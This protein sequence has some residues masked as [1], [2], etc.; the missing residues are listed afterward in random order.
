MKIGIVGFGHLGKSLVKGLIRSN[1]V[2]PSDIYILAKSD[3]TKQKAKEQYG[4]YPADHIN[5]LVEHA[6]I[7]FWVVKGSAMKDICSELTVDIKQ[8][9]NI[10]FMAGISMDVLK[11]YLGD[12]E[13][14]RAMPNIAIENA[15]GIIG[16]TPTNNQ[17]I[18]DIFN[19]LGYSFVVEE[20]DIEKVTAFSACGLGF[21]AYILD[22]FYKTGIDLG[23]PV[24]VSEQIVAKTFISAIQM[25]DYEN[26]V[27]EVA[28][29]GGAT[30]QGILHLDELNANRII[31]DAIHQAYNKVK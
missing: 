9:P 26:I 2:R 19:C 21:A 28:T 30:E 25:S 6:D 8:K 4:V 5:N 7:I 16:Y 20:K 11:Q 13:V 23:F 29:K 10:S 24:E 3:R 27:K 12:V 14:I 31:N 17:A 15:D 18:I 1:I 22:A